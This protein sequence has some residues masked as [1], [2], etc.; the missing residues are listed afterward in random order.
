MRKEKLILI[1]RMSSRGIAMRY[2]I[3]SSLQR[4]SEYWLKRL[5]ESNRK[6]TVELNSEKIMPKTF[7]QD[8]KAFKHLESFVWTFSVNELTLN[9]YYTNASCCIILFMI[10][11]FFFVA[12]LGFLFTKEKKA[13]ESGQASS[14]LTDW[15]NP[16]HSSGWRKHSDPPP[17]CRWESYKIKR[18]DQS[19]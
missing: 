3:A 17:R 7:L 16:S 9:T 1:I 19:S 5:D 15:S 11:F 12:F 18:H 8:L 10:C 14:W 2:N 4:E 13:D 6:V